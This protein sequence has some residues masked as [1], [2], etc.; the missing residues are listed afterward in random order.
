[1]YTI[2]YVCRIIS[3]M[4]N[5]RRVCVQYFIFPYKCHCYVTSFFVQIPVMCSFTFSLHMSVLC[6]FISPY[7]CQLYV[8]LIFPYKCQRYVYLIFLYKFQC[9]VLCRYCEHFYF[10]CVACSL[11]LIKERKIYNFLVIYF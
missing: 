11:C 10:T 2:I 6:Y 5:F 3:N 7:K 8:Y 4:N 1:M 9:Y